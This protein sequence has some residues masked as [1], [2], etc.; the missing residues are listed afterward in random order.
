MVV[1]KSS[2]FCELYTKLHSLESGMN[3]ADIAR[4]IYASFSIHQAF[5]VI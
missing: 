1:D 4:Q 3:V 5:E 2:C